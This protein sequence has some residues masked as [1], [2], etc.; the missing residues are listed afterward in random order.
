MSSEN[1]C[2]QMQIKILYSFNDNSTTFLSRSSQQFP[3]QTVEVPM[4]SSLSDEPE[5][6][7]LG[8]F[9]I[10]GCARQLLETNPENF[11]LQTE[12][13]AIYYKDITEQP[14]EPFVSNGTL[15]S[16]LK[17]KESCLIP[18]RVCQNMSANILFG[19]KGNTSSLTLE[20]RLKLHTVEASKMPHQ[21][22]LVHTGRTSTLPQPASRQPSVSSS[23]SRPERKR[24]AEYMHSSSTSASAS[25]SSSSSSSAATA[26]VKAT[27]TLSLPL[28]SHIHSIQQA[29]R[30]SAPRYNRESVENR[31]KSASFYQDKVVFDKSEK[32]QKRYPN[33]LQPL[34]PLQSRAS[35]SASQLLPQRAVRTRSMFTASPAMQSS[36]GAHEDMYSSDDPEYKAGEDQDALIEEEGEGDE[37]EE[38]EEEDY[39][40][41]SPATP[42]QPPYVSKEIP[43]E[44]PEDLDSKRT[45]TISN[46]KLPENHGLV[47]INSCCHTS[48]SINWKYF[49]TEFKPHFS[50]LIRATSFNKKHYEGM[51]GPL[52]NACFLFYKNKGFMRPEHVVR[53]Y[54]QQQRYNAKLKLK[55]AGGEEP[56]QSRPPLA[57]RK[58]LASSPTNFPTPSHTPS[59]INQVIQNKY[60]GGG[61]N[62]NSN[63]YSLNNTNPT[64]TNPTPDNELMQQLGVYGGPCT[65]IDPLPGHT[66]PV[67]AARS[68][69][70]VINYDEELDA[71]KAAKQNT[72]VINLYHDNDEDKENVPPGSVVVPPGP[73]DLAEI[74]AMLNSIQCD[75]NA[76]WMNLFSPRDH[77]SPNSKTPVDQPATSSSKSANNS[78]NN[79]NSNNSSKK[80]P[81][82]SKTNSSMVNMPSSPYFSQSVPEEDHNEINDELKQL[83]KSSGFQSSPD[84]ANRTDTATSLMNWQHHSDSGRGGQ[85]TGA[86]NK[87]LAS[88][89][90]SEIFFSNDD[91]GRGKN[92]MSVGDDLNSEVI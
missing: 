77:T 48:N 52:C 13:Y 53:K 23:V 88:T 43:F 38:D 58:N 49:E 78:T 85:M 79:N 75:A 70:R 47:C 86:A 81:S 59:V 20:I 36:P 60:H 26:A 27:R 29:D 44:L 50:E 16:L 72:R 3:V 68:N 2:K 31:F 33:N 66:P 40:A 30:V 25:S 32:R 9:E 57:A 7:T 12:D 56:E 83:V 67:V 6:I 55:S 62:N 22:S 71:R 64:P 34:P 4:H 41:T 37:D 84:R 89:P 5:M 63:N 11:K 8:A 69:T 82:P 35:A 17:T 18:G 92:G 65:D 14:D 45:H 51:F 73:S 15:S 10:E 76:Q 54:N 74:D 24:P 19:K 61:N 1:G 80:N 46:T 42:Q 21:E 87:D 39:D 28:S 91:C 90:G